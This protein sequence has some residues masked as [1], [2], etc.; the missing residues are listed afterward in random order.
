MYAPVKPVGCK[1]VL[2]T[3]TGYPDVMLGIRKVEF[4]EL[5]RWVSSIEN[6]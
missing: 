6:F 1:G 4:S 2:I 5:E 3:R